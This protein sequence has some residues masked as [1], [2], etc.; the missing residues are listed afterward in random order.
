[1]EGEKRFLSCLLTATLYCGMCVPSAGT[2]KINVIKYPYKHVIT[3]TYTEMSMYLR[4]WP[5]CC[6][7]VSAGLACAKALVHTC[8]SLEGGRAIWVFS[9]YR[10]S[11][12]GV[13]PHPR[14]V[15]I[16]TLSVWGGPKVSCQ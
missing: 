10:H 15:D 8:I 5:E 9:E 13:T 3:Q 2:H 12:L 16:W 6:S 7:V 4:M 14:C 11:Q 1:M